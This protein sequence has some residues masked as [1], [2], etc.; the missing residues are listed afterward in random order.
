MNL[1]LSPP[2]LMTR[3]PEPLIPDEAQAGLHRRAEE[4]LHILTNFAMDESGIVRTMLHP[5]GFRPL[6][7]AEISKD[8]SLCPP[9]CSAAGFVSYEDA[10]MATGALLAALSLKYQR[11]GKERDR[12]AA[13]RAF[14]ALRK[15]YEM[16][17]EP[18]LFSKPYDGRGSAH[19]SRDQ[20]LF[21]LA[22]LRA[23]RDIATET[24]IRFI[25]TMAAAMC[26]FWIKRDYKTSYFGIPASSQ[27]NDYMAGL[28][29][30]LIHLGWQLS[31]D[32]LLLEEYERLC[33]VHSLDQ[34]MA[35]TLKDQFQNGIRY[36]GAMYFRQA[37]NA[38]MMKAI[39]IDALWETDPDRQPRWR[40][41][42]ETFWNGELLAS[43]NPATGLNYYIVG[44]RP[45]TDGFFLT[46]PGVIPELENP[47]NFSELTWGGLRQRPGSVQ[48]AFVAAVIAARL[49]DWNS[50]Q[51]ARLILSALDQSKFRG[52]TVPSDSHIPPQ[53]AWQLHTIHTGY[54]AMWLWAYYRG[55]PT[56]GQ[57]G[58]D[59]SGSA[60]IPS[61][62]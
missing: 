41:A 15:I 56:A 17:A 52:L 30:G 55:F 40:Q 54:M 18:G 37:E 16:G 21:C 39:A 59:S 35:E 38:L 6:R 25:G 51:V 20:Y 13:R 22:G 57:I 14:L 50:S 11:E 28:F 49:N 27:L 26:R 46:A 10:G 9:D 60:A 45:E 3:P 1:D 44:Y 12:A 62:A 5:E 2:P 7:D 36:D 53:M 4:Y 47:L 42:L 19:L 32:A 34:R 33:Q 8:H 61:G 58:T 23:Y 24:E 29:L 43:L 48:T 31:G